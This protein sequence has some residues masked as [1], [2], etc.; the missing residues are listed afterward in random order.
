MPPETT[1]FR[2]G[3]TEPS[4]NAAVPELMSRMICNC[5]EA[6]AHP[7]APM[8]LALFQRVEILKQPPELA[9]RA[10][11]LKPGDAAYLLTGLR[12][13]VAK[14]LALALLAGRPSGEIDE[15]KEANDE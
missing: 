8:A 4:R 2:S 7:D 10:L 5:A 11:G 9:A 14:D 3:A 6:S 13:E 15:Q 12:E 1:N